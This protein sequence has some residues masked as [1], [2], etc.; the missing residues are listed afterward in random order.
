[1]LIGGG[2]TLIV[3][4]LVLAVGFYQEYIVKPAA[5]I[6]VVNEQAITTREYQLMVRYRRF[7]LASQVAMLQN[8]LARLDPTAEDQQFLVQYLQQQI[9]QVQARGLSLP[10][11]VL[12]EMIDDEIVRQEAARRDI[13]ITTEEVQQEIERLFGY[14]RNPPTPTPT[15][16]TATATITV[17]PAPTEP[18][19]TEEDFQKTY[20][21]YVVALRKN[22][23]L[24]E[25]AFRRLFESGIYQRKLQEA[26][27]EE[28]PTAEE[29]VHARH[30]LVETEEEAQEVLERLDAG[31]D[32]AALADELS[33]DTSTEGG[34]LGWFARGQMV[35]EFEEV[36][37]ALDSGET[38]HVVETSFGYHVINLIERDPNRPLDEATLDRRKASALEEWLSE[39]RYSDA[40]ER[41]WSSDKVPP[42]T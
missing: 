41:Y 7:E 14:D 20:G 34:D 19:M 24:T 22:V 42:T 2:L 18:P 12:D 13:V 9:Q 39:Q 28:V 17:T 29:Q 33:I 23:G 31:E 38:S 40:I 25:A 21:E 32:F 4:V 1:V 8:Q 10:S 5:P 6:A 27:A 15:P 26:L 36:A 35:L 30:I 11:Q 37:F 16:I 3:I